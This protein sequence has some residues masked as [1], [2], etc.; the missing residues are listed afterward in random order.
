MTNGLGSFY[1]S[2]QQQVVPAAP[3]DNVQQEVGNQQIEVHGILGPNIRQA[4][5]PRAQQ[6][7]AT[8]P[9]LA[10]VRPRADSA[11]VTRHEIESVEA[12]MIMDPWSRP[13][14]YNAS[15]TP[16]SSEGDLEID[17]ADLAT[18]ANAPRSRPAVSHDNSAR[19]G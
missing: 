8:N 5:A 12:T 11:P 10:R 7:S 17:T 14:T 9:A 6:T 18:P 2:A 16:H 1:S 19:G 3:S 15:E 13:S 4:A